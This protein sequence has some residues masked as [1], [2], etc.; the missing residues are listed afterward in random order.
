MKYC[1]LRRKYQTVI[2]RMEG[3]LELKYL[4]DGQVL[5]SGS[6]DRCIDKN[7]PT[8]LNNI[9]YV[10]PVDPRLKAGRTAAALVIFFFIFFYLRSLVLFLFDF[11]AKL[12]QDCPLFRQQEAFSPLRLTS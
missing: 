9:V 11:S 1:P 2:P 10:K 7:D 5:C 12:P 4:V 8:K 3:L 6:L